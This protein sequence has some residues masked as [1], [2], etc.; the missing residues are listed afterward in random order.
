[1]T[2]GFLV[3]NN[4]TKETL[5]KIAEIGI[6]VLPALTSPYFLRYIVK[7]YFKERNK[8]RVRA[9][10]DLKKKKLID[11]QELKDGSIKVC[12]TENG[13]KIILQYELENLKIEKPKRWDGKWRVIIYDIPQ[14]LRKASDAFRIKIRELGM[15]QLQKSIW[16][17]PYDCIKELD[18]VCA[19]YQVPLE[20]CV[21]YF[22]AEEL[23][24][25]KE[26][27]QFFGL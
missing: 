23:P 18:F 4:I 19:I 15:Y 16:I 13:K 6:L 20:N 11:I 21:L 26:I 22:K 10:T 27:K 9:I 5:L 25:Q 3:K 7:K 2:R 24:K 8:K 14:S 12:L 1:M 17:Y